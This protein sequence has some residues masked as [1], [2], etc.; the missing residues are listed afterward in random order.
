[1]PTQLIKNERA[2]V[3]ARFVDN[4]GDK[5]NI[6]PGAF[7]YADGYDGT[8]D[9][10]LMFGCPCGCGALN[11]VHL[12]RYGSNHPVWQWDGNRETPTLTPSI[13]I[14]QLNDKAERIGEHWHGF[15]TAGVFRSC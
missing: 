6:E 2:T 7:H 12:K 1:M 10:C 3:P 14:Y 11:A 8:K 15:L 5:Q 13:L 4:F 9:V